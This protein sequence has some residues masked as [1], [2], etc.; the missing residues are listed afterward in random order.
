MAGDTLFI[1]TRQG[2]LRALDRHTGETLWKFPLKGEERNRAVYGVPAV[3]EDRLYLGGYDSFLYSLSHDGGSEWE[4]RVGDS[5][6][7]GPLVVDNT[8]VVGSSDGNLYAFD[9]EKELELWRFPVGAEVWSAPAAADG[10]VYFGSL[11]H[12]VYAVDLEEGSRV[13]QFETAG[14]VAAAPLVV[15]GTVYVGSFDGVFYALDA[16]TGDEE[17]RFEEASNWYWAGAVAGE[18]A[19]Y[20]PSLDGNLYALDASTGELLWTLETDGPVVGSPAIV[21]DMIAVGSGDGKIRLARLRDGLELDAC[22]IGEGIRASLVEKGGIIYFAARD[23]SIR[24]LQIKAN[25]N[26]DELWVHYTDRDDPLPRDQV[27]AC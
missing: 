3:T 15:G 20:A 18:G 5:I 23:H 25:G 17:W 16:K 9:T 4:E 2:E 26:P 12:N 7:G 6:V 10:I 11:D 8:L 21:S 24:A 22:N 1:G 13:W 19:V 27:H 14:A